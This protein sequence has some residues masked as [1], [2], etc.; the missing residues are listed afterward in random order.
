MNDQ[1]LLATKDFNKG[2][3]ISIFSLMNDNI[4]DFWQKSQ[5]LDHIYIE[6]LKIKNLSKNQIEFNSCKTGIV[7]IS[8]R[9]IHF[10]SPMQINFSLDLSEQNLYLLDYFID[11]KNCPEALD[12][13]RYLFYMFFSIFLQNM[14]G[15]NPEAYLSKIYSLNRKIFELLND[16]KEKN[17]DFD[18]TISLPTLQKKCER[19]LKNNGY[20]SK[21]ISLIKK[22]I[23]K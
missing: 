23:K 8:P 11:K 9:K 10:A 13:Y 19:Y 1:Y 3:I 18:D 21:R 16:H 20:P 22:I 5:N 14:K 2:L 4:Q 15:L 6:L 17:Q 12:K 7:K